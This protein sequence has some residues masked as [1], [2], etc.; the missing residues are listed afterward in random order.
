[1]RRLVAAIDQ[2]DQDERRRINQGFGASLSHAFEIAMVPLVFAGF[3]WLLDR[4]VH[5]GWVF[6]ATFAVIGLAGTF[7]KLY[8]GYCQQMLE[9]EEAGPWRRIPQ[10]RR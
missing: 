2:R 9:L 7:V 3:G 8:Y 5:T 6:A 10:A 1:M 4:L